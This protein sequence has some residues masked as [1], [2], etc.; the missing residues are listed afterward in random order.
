MLLR[1]LKWKKCLVNCLGKFQIKC[2]Q[3]IFLMNTIRILK[4][5]DEY[6]NKKN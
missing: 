3:Q 6:L 1:L 5:K 4:N 2:N